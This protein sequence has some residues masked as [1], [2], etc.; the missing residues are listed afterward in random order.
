MNSKR[1]NDNWYSSL[2]GHVAES[3]N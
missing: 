3:L 2:S 1:V